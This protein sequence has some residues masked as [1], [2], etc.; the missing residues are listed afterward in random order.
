MLSNSAQSRI[1]DFDYACKGHEK[2]VASAKFSNDVSRYVHKVYFRNNSDFKCSYFVRVASVSGDKTCRIWCTR[3]GKLAQILVGHASGVCDLAW[4]NDDKIIATG[5]DD[6]FLMLWDSWTGKCIRLLAGHE[7]SV[8]CCAFDVP[9]NVLASGSFDETLRLWEV[10]KGKC[11]LVIPAH[12]D[13]IS[14]ICFSA[15]GSMVLTGSYDGSLRFWDK[16]SGACLKSLSISNDEVV[17]ISFLSSTP[18]PSF[19]L[20]GTLSDSIMLIDIKSG[21]IVKKY[22]SH[23]TRQFCLPP[24]YVR[25]K[26]AELIVCGSENGHIYLWD[27]ISQQV[28][29]A[30]P[31]KRFHEESSDL[32]VAVNIAMGSNSAVSFFLK[33]ST[34]YELK[35]WKLSDC[36]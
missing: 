5:S 14:S 30:L 2:T 1:F 35:L 33:N 21:K 25:N 16:N 20:L 27:S 17:P 19:M 12:S 29:S 22:S 34:D 10:K 13:P 24:C 4:S 11:M 7:C 26:E 3:T 9:N 6:T 23:T 36:K 8:T 15:D 18:N 32:A 28:L 31:I